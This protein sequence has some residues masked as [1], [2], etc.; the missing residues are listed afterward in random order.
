MKAVSSAR[1]QNSKRKT[2]NKIQGHKS[3]KKTA[4]ATLP[5]PFKMIVKQ[6]KPT[7]QHFQ[8]HKK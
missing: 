2:P 8:R 4:T 5:S 7:N 6:V 3:G 1:K